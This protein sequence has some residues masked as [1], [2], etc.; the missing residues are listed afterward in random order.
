MI[1]DLLQDARYAARTLCRSPAFTLLAVLSL[2]L[3]IGANTAVFSVVNTVLIRSLPYQNPDRL[4][5]LVDLAGQDAISMDTLQFFEEQCQV[6]F[7]IA[8]HK[9]VAERQ[10]GFGASQTW[11][12]VLPVTGQ[13]LSVLGIQP[14]LGRE[15]NSDELRTGGPRAVLIS[16]AIWKNLFHGDPSILGRTVTLDET[17][18]YTIVGV[19]PSGY[20]FPQTSDVLTALRPTGGVDDTG[21]NTQV[22]AQL[23]AGVSLKQA[24]AE[25]ANISERYRRS[26]TAEAGKK[27]RGIGAVGFQES[28]VGDVRVMMLLALGVTGLLLMMACSNLVG[29]LLTRLTSRRREIAIRLAIGGSSWPVMRGFIVENVIVVA[30]AAAAGLLTAHWTLNGML[31]MIPF[32]LHSSAPVSLDL[33]VLLFTFTITVATAGLLTLAALVDVSRLDVLEALQSGGR[34][35][36]PGLGRQWTRNLLVIGQIAMASSLLIPAGLLIRSMYVLRSERLG[37][38]SQGVVSFQTP[39]SRMRVQSSSATSMFARDATERL[40]SLPWVTGVGAVNLLPL[41]GPSNLPAQ[42]DGHPEH[43][44][45]G[46][47]IR[48]VTTG[49][50]EAMGITLRRGRTINGNDLRVSTPVAVINESLANRW[51]PDAEAVGDR[52]VVGRFRGKDFPELKDSPREVIGVVE[53]TKTLGV[54]ERPRPTLYLP[55]SQAPDAFIGITGSISWVLKANGPVSI[56]E[57]ENAIREHNPNQTVRRFQTLDDLVA[58]STSDSRFDAWVFGTFAAVAF[59]LAMTGMYG[60]IAYSVTQRTQELGIRIALGGTRGDILK[61]ILRRGLLLTVVGLA[62]GTGAALLISKWLQQLLFGV[63]ATDALSFMVV[64][65]LMI[66]SGLAASYVPARRASRVDPMQSLRG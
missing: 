3:G 48:L 46:T 43:S 35:A 19:L 26:G 38:K 66:T 65:A 42:H 18:S 30:L 36:S 2:G 20:W 63:R 49:Y 5:R 34:N 14:A 23:K 56:N 44:F 7:S 53:N 8:G 15:F 4:I 60:L 39:L 58:S 47:E 61:L 10:L 24:Q 52:V 25:F 33:N 27:F 6:C 16:N 29:L 9:G 21:A 40:R 37:F 32:R 28:L 22:I 55:F 41:S 17:N 45:G 51:W 59:A 1:G 54:R 11:A 50:F 13:F 57:V 62:L 31:A 64:I 12:T